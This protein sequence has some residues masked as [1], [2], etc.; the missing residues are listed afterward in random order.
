[1]HEFLGY[2]PDV[3][4]GTNSE[5]EQPEASSLGRE[6][7]DA[8]QLLRQRLEAEP[9]LLQN[10]QVLAALRIVSGELAILKQL[11]R[12]GSDSREESAKILGEDPPQPAP[13]E[14][15]RSVDSE[16]SR[17]TEPTAIEI[18]A[19]R[20]AEAFGRL[21]QLIQSEPHLLNDEDVSA[22]LRRAIAERATLRQFDALRPRS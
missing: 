22:Q 6:G 18:D 14:I 3:G 4:I 9:S 21:R 5:D 2:T 10:E 8:L 17:E 11:A 16:R 20:A 1:M 15:G 12:K 7:A 13:S 19:N